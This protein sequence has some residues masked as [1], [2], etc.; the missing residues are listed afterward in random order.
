M[1]EPTASDGEPGLS[2]SLIELKRILSARFVGQAG[3]HA[4]G[5]RKSEDTICVYLTPGRGGPEQ[6]A[7]L[8]D[9]EVAARP[10]RVITIVEEPPSFT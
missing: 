10:H 8:A 3:V 9:I 5:L 4:L 6:S 7:V 2:Q 1:T